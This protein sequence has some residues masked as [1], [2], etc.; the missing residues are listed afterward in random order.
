MV[1]FTHVAEDGR[2][3]TFREPMKDDTES[4]MSFINSVVGERMSGRMITQK[5]TLKDEAQWLS[6]RL[7]EI[8]GRRTVILLVVDGGRVLGSCHISRL[9]GKHSHRASIGVALRKEIRGQGIGEAIMKRTI[10]MGIRRFKGLESVDLTAFAYNDRA[11]ALYRKLG[12]VEYGRV[13]RSAKE[14]S[15]YVDEVLMRKEVCPTNRGR[16]PKGTRRTGI[17]TRGR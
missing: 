12:F 2:E 13:P 7:S 14:G 11:L 17:S 10:E 16:G 4:L 15:Q 1:R 9:S 3:F 8:R 6:G 5:V